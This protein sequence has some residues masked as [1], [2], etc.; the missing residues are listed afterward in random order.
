M[1]SIMNSWPSVRGLVHSFFPFLWRL[2]INIPTS[3]KFRTL[4][5]TSDLRELQEGLASVHVR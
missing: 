2:N 5:S 1:L 4:G 3:I